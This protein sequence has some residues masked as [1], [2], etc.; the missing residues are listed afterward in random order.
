M[1]YHNI[2]INYEEGI[3]VL[4]TAVSWVAIMIFNFAGTWSNSQNL[5]ASIRAASMAT[6]P[7]VNVIMDKFEKLGLSE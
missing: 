4:K 5:F 2:P 6:L 3:H 7:W 1:D